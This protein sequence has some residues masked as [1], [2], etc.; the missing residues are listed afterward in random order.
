MNEP[1]ELFKPIL[2]DDELE[3]LWINPILTENLWIENF[4]D[5]GVFEPINTCWHS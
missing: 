5:S 4:L 3:N 2:N 1:E